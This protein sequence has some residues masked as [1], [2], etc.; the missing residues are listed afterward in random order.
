MQSS[1]LA[2]Y[3][4]IPLCYSPSWSL[5]DDDRV[6][7]QYHNPRDKWLTTV[8]M[9]YHLSLYWWFYFSNASILLSCYAIR[10]IK[11]GVYLFISGRQTLFSIKKISCRRHLSLRLTRCT[12]SSTL[13]FIHSPSIHASTTIRHPSVF[14]SF[15]SSHFP[16]PQLDR[17]HSFS[18]NG[19]NDF[20][21]FVLPIFMYLMLLEINEITIS[22]GYS[23]TCVCRRPKSRS[24][25]SNKYP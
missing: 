17:F 25:D 20:V 23:V 10:I 7:T 11:V 4:R 14:Y 12:F 24:I 18:V 16:L 8:I 6:F 22:R 2:K 9:K 15:P 21:E 1:S 5:Q 13:A 19:E 3:L